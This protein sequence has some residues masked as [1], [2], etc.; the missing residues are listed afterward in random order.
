MLLYAREVS[1]TD[2]ALQ[3]YHWLAAMRLE[4]LVRRLASHHH[5]FI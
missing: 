5:T 2:T 4:V 1:R 3:N